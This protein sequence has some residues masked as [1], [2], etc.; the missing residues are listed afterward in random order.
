[1]PF[2]RR[3]KQLVDH[4]RSHSGIT[5]ERVLVAIESIPR[6]R[7][8][9]QGSELEAWEDI[10]LP[11]AALEGFTAELESTIA[12]RW[13]GFEVCIFGHVGDGNLHVNF[14]WDDMS[15]Y[16]RVDAA[17]ADLMRATVALG[18]TLSGEHGIGVAKAPYVH[19][20]Q[21]EGL[22]DLQKK[23]KSVFDPKGLLNPGK[24]FSSGAHK[25]C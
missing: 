20:E 22:V 16:P 14:L 9:L 12:S 4:L 6:E 15:D 8:V 17:V 13:P 24:I 7:F 11:I 1:M 2:T 18:G 5:D 10:A 19:L 23:L 21:S 25:A 3:K